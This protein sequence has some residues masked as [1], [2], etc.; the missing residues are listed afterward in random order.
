[1]RLPCVMAI[2]ALL[3]ASAAS[4]QPATPSDHLLPTAE[5]LGPGWVELTYTLPTGDPDYP[6][7]RGW[8]AGPDGSRVTLLVS[9]PPAD[10]LFGIWEEIAEGVEADAPASL[11]SPEHPSGT[12]PPI[13]GCAAVRRVQGLPV[14]FPAV[15][16]AITACRTSDAILHARVSGTWQGL[17]GT[18]ASDALIE[19]LLA[20][21]IGRTTNTEPTPPAASLAAMLPSTNEVPPG[22][23]LESDGAIAAGAMP[24]TFPAPAEAA[25]RL[26]RWGWQENAYRNFVAAGDPPPGA[27]S[28]VEISL[29]Q[30]ASDSGAASALPYFAEARSE[31]RGLSVAPIEQMRTDEAAVVGQGAEGNEATLYLRLGDVLVR[32]TAVVPHGSAENVAREVADVVVDKRSQPDAD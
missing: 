3:F 11:L 5:D 26:A 22:L 9:V 2:C 7:A 1:M 12:I 21:R 24:L 31:A 15:T 14:S 25:E 20:H 23:T 13:A 30:F 8:Y 19:L 10:S 6:E 17:A 27:P 16:E 32:I 4:A 28:S 29:H 18:A